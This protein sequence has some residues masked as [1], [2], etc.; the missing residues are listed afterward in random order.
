MSLKEVIQKQQT[1]LKEKMPE[2]FKAEPVVEKKKS[3]PKTSPVKNVTFKEPTNDTSKG[4]VQKTANDGEL[5]FLPKLNY[6]RQCPR[7]NL[8]KKS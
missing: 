3:S 1:D 4:L 2:M 8:N 5:Y 7:R 6:C